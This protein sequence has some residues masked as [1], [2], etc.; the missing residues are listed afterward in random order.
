M[1][2]ERG[3][4]ACESGPERS[5]AARACVGS[6]VRVSEKRCGV[7]GVSLGEQGNRGEYRVGRGDLDI[8]RSV[9]EKMGEG[10][11][12]GMSR[13]GDP[14]RLDCGKC[15]RVVRV[16]AGGKSAYICGESRKAMGKASGVCEGVGRQKGEE[17]PKK[18]NERNIIS[19]RQSELINN[20]RN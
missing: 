11:S 18:I 3:G 20:S 19:R 5:M 14:R 6:V 1:A 16:C 15:C 4:V 10:I 12:R 13:S 2:G 7:A 9:V 8:V 17:K